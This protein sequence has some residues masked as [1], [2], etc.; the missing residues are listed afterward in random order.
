MEFRDQSTIRSACRHL[1]RPIAAMM[2]KC[3]MTWREFSELSKSVFVESATLDYGIKGRPT[4]VSRVSILT[5]ISRKEVKR[6]RDLLVS[7]QPVTTRKTT[8][9][10]RLLSGWHQDPDF[11]DQHGQPLPLVVKGQSPNFSELFARYGGD[12]SEQSLVKELRNAKAVETDESGRL[13]AKSRYYMPA[14]VSN[15]WI[16]MA[17]QFMRDLGTNINF[18]MEA[19]KDRD[20]RFLGF[21]VDH[22]ISPKA[23]KEFREF[24]EKRGQQF[25]QETDDWLEQ[26]K[27]NTQVDTTAKPIRLGVGLFTLQNETT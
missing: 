3:G 8:D 2:L 11:S 19:D 27:I 1:L 15:E 7:E 20:S 6:Q 9:A 10:T 25:L 23:A 12:T 24:M 16:D 26:H 22:E 5:G 18:N 17:G 14:Q 13:V 21:A 4:N